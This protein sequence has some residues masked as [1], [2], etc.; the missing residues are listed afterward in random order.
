[1]WSLKYRFYTLSLVVFL[2]LAVVGAFGC[3]P[4]VSS[5]TIQSNVQYQ[6]AMHPTIVSDKP[7][8]CPICGMRLVKIEE[9]QTITA[10][11]VPGHAR[12]KISPERQQLIGV[13]TSVAEEMPLTT[14]IHVAG[15]VAYNPDIANTLAE[16][17]DAYQAYW[18]TRRSSNQIA[19][20]RAEELLELAEMKLRLAGFSDDQMDQI[21]VTSK[22]GQYFYNDVFVTQNR[23]LPA[24]SAWI[25]ADLYESDSELIQLGQGVT[26]T[27][28]AL[29]GREFSGEVKTRD[30]VLNAMTRILRIRIEVPTADGLQP[31]MSA[32]VKINV[33]LGTKLAV[34]EEA[35]FHTG[36]TQL[37]FVD[38]GDGL[39]EPR[40]VKTGYPA[41]GYYEILSGLASGETVVTSAGFLIDSESRLRAALQSFSGTKKGEAQGEKGESSDLPPAHVH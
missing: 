20:E 35:V 34:P 27:L 41:D 16:Y 39:I 1:M 38:T 26:I 32:D 7:G 17:R 30:P 37:V 6:C 40:E 29:P 5:E 25:Y 21:L 31:G 36:H 28:P 18:K 9:D 12:I 8:N 33:P 22:G 2:S 24:G 19:R 11:V 13:T 4:K 3:K 15:H 14:S 23:T 10:V